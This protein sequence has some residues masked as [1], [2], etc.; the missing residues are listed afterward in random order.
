MIQIGVF[1]KNVKRISNGGG[2]SY[3]QDDVCYNKHKLFICFIRGN[4][5]EHF[6]HHHYFAVVCVDDCYFKQK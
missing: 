5:Y 6:K 1:T 2:V 3:E 4:Y